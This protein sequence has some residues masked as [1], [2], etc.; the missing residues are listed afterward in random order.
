MFPSDKRE[1]LFCD[2]SNFLMKHKVKVTLLNSIQGKAVRGGSKPWVSTPNVCNKPRPYGHHYDEFGHHYDEYNDY[3]DDD[4]DEYNEYDN[5]DNYASE[6]QLPHN[7][8]VITMLIMNHDER[9]FCQK[10]R[11]YVNMNVCSE[12]ILSDDLDFH[13]SLRR[14][15]LPL[16]YDIYTNCTNLMYSTKQWLWLLLWWWSSS[17]WCQ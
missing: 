5:D 12:L 3:D 11:G 10:S 6:S 9:L 1:K 15:I 2:K 7:D 4:N 13:I 16:Q 14:M 8:L 17:S